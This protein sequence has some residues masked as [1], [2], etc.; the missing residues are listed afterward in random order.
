MNHSVKIS[1]DEQRIINVVR[2]GLSDDAQ[3]G[4]WRSDKW[5]KTFDQLN[6]DGLLITQMPFNQLLMVVSSSAG[7]FISGQRGTQISRGSLLIRTD[8]DKVYCVDASSWYASE[9]HGAIVYGVQGLHLIHPTTV[10]GKIKPVVSVR[11][12]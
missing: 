6:E 8:F 3:K 9:S 11:L 5:Y 12:S 1:E 7:T 2:K 4:P 10:Y